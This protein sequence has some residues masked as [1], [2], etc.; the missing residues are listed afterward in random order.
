MQRTNSISRTKSVQNPYRIPDRVFLSFRHGGRLG[1]CR[2]RPLP[3][4]RKGARRSSG[5][6]PGSNT[7]FQR[8]LGNLA[9]DE[10][11]LGQVQTD[12]GYGNAELGVR[13]RDFGLTVA[14][15]NC[16]MAEIHSDIRQTNLV[17]ANF[18][19]GDDVH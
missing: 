12:A 4:E 19:V 1:R 11:V 6:P 5:R 10:V 13:H 17:H 15:G 9:E 14:F 7:R 8:I 2:A 16:D 3:T 18:E